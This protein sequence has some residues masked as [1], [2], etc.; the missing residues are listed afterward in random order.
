MSEI[1]VKIQKVLDSLEKYERSP[2]PVTRPNQNLSDKGPVALFGL[3]QQDKLAF[4]ERGIEDGIG[5]E[6]IGKAIGWIGYAVF[7]SYYQSKYKKELDEAG[8]LMDGPNKPG[9]KN[10]VI[11]KGNHFVQRT[12]KEDDSSWPEWPKMETKIKNLHFIIID[13]G[14]FEK[15]DKNADFLSDIYLK[16]NGSSNNICFHAYIE[17]ELVA[18]KKFFDVLEIVM[19]NKNT[20]CGSIYYDKVDTPHEEKYRISNKYLNN[21]IKE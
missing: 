12:E 10:N 17:N 5:W 21:F 9:T 6:E 15:H 18:S 16:N 8:L 19:E 14:K 2:F 20:W 4:V 7:K 11:V 1:K 3:S 13:K